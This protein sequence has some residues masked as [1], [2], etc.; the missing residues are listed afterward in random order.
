[1]KCRIVEIQSGFFYVKNLCCIGEKV[2]E[3]L[4]LNQ[5]AGYFRRKRVSSIL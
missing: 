2:R 1:M 4:L 5:S 3:L